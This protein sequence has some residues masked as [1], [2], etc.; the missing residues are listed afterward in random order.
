MHGFGVPRTSRTRACAENV[1]SGVGAGSVQHRRTAVTY[2]FA[3][4]FSAPLRTRVLLDC[5]VI[6]FNGPI[7]GISVAFNG[8]QS[9][10]TIGFSFHKPEIK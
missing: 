5:K 8:Q 7:I 4:I 2:G 9:E 1:R 3:K 6:A 10:S